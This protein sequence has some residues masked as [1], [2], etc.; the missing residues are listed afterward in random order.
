M[1]KGREVTGAEYSRLWREANPEKQ[2]AIEK[3]AY[4]A[5]KRGREERRRESTSYYLPREESFKLREAF[6]DGGWHK[7]GE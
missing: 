2:K 4:E 6:E 7:N 5:R 3:R 1:W